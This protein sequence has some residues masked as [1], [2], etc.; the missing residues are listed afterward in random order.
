[1]GQ[2]RK[3]G[4]EGQAPNWPQSSVQSHVNVDQQSR[5]QT[6]QIENED[7]VDRMDEDMFTPLSPKTSMWSNNLMEKQADQMHFTPPTFT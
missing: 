2:K 1:M 6:D 4:W 3:G 7:D 5:D